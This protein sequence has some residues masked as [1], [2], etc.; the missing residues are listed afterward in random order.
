MITKD[1]LLIFEKEGKTYKQIGDKYDLSRQRIEQL[2]NKLLGRPKRNK[3]RRT[4]LNEKI[5]NNAKSTCTWCGKQ[6]ERHIIKKEVLIRGE[7]IIKFFT[8]NNVRFCS[9]ECRNEK[10]KEVMNNIITPIR[11]TDEQRKKSSEF[12]TKWWAENKERKIEHSEKMKKRW[13]NKEWK[14]KVLEARRKVKNG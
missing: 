8:P 9:K 11:Q 10:M 4:L 5:L 2:F 1:E 13:K 12:K 3:Y 6:F 7:K 14:N